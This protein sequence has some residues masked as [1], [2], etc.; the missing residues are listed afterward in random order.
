M[1]TSLVLNAAIEN[2]IKG[3]DPNADN[4]KL[5]IEY[6]SKLKCAG[7]WSLTISF[8]WK[9]RDSF[10]GVT[11]ELGN[12]QI[13]EDKI[14]NKEIGKIIKKQRIGHYRIWKHDEGHL[15]F[16]HY[17]ASSI[18]TGSDDTKVNTYH[19]FYDAKTM[20]EQ[21]FAE[22]YIYRVKKYRFWG[23]VLILT[24]TMFDVKYGTVPRHYRKFVL[25]REM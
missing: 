9:K 4:A 7:F 20:K 12:V 13:D 22:E 17:W 23:R 25:N 24:R 8:P 3:Q 19:L 18:A 2:L 5:V 16:H 15:S 6:G 21:A 10:K 11:S 14:E 1:H